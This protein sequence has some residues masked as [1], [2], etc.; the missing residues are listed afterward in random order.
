MESDEQICT[1]LIT[2]GWK[3]GEGAIT[4]RLVTL[5]LGVDSGGR[6]EG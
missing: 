6:S 5:T 4:R 2:E 3:C 1:L